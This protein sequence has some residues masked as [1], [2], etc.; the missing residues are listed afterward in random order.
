MWKRLHVKYQLFMADFNETWISFNRFSKKA[1]IPSSIKIRPVG[2][3][4]FNAEG[5]TDMTNIIV[6]FRSLANAP[7]NRYTFWRLITV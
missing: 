4:L 5:Q 2:A 1:Q 6:A 3:E 7:K